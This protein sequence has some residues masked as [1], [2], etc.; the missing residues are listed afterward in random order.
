MDTRD[1]I[2]VLLALLVVATLLGF[3]WQSRQGRISRHTAQALPP[4]LPRD[5]LDPTSRFTLLQFSGPFCSYCDA[6]RGVLGRAAENFRGI[7]SHREIDV[8]DH[9]E[10]VRRLRI[11]QTPTTLIVTNTGHIVTRIQGA[12]KPP[13]IDQEIRNAIELRKAASDEYLI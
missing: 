6:M 3:V 1:V 12:A 13:V 4:D 10:L 5:V 2:L 9:Q 7:V 8:T 11:S